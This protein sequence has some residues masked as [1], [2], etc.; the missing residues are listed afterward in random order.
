[1]HTEKQAALAAIAELPDNADMNEIMYRL[2]V[3]GKIRQGREDVVQGRTI[4][5]EELEREI[6]AW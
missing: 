1:M 3:L 5:S 4:S 6:A 2:Y